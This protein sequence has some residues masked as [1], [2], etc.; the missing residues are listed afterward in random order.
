MSRQQ[1]QGFLLTPPLSPVLEAMKLMAKT[2]VQDALDTYESATFKELQTTIMKTATLETKLA[3]HFISLAHF[4]LAPYTDD[5]TIQARVLLL[6]TL[7]LSN[8]ESHMA[9]IWREVIKQ[10][11][12]IDAEDEDD[13][14]DDEMMETIAGG[15]ALPGPQDVAV[16]NGFL[17]AIFGITRAL[18]WAMQVLST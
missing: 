1:Q 18:G 4:T 15:P 11:D 17:E 9:D 7:A 13:S 12:W 6:S 10:D 8:M 16:P 3:P 14:D 2:M 5:Y